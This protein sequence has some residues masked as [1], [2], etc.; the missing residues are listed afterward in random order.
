MKCYN[1]PDRD[2]VAQY[3]KCG[4]LLCKECADKYT[5]CLCDEC[6]DELRKEEL[7]NLKEAKKP[8]VRTIV[9]GAL[10]FLA[11]FFLIALS[12]NM[13]LI[14]FPFIA[15]FIPF[16]WRYANLLGLTWSFNLNA[17]GFLLMFFVY[18]FRICV[19]VI[20]GIPCFLIAL[21]KLYKISAAAKTAE[22]EEIN[23]NN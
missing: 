13:D 16:G 1:H 9:C 20:L 21:I 11:I 2:A 23:N 12:G 8:F 7:E 6:Y 15:F 3:T 18:S 4:K 17:A 19:A 22:I 10:F 5:P 14:I